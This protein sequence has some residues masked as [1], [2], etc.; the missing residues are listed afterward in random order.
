[1]TF[2]LDCWLV[3]SSLCG[4]VAGGPALNPQRKEQ[5]NPSFIPLFLHSFFRHLLHWLCKWKESEA[6]GSIPFEFVC[7]L[8]SSLCAPCAGWPPAHNRP[9][10]RAEDQTQTP[11]HSL[12]A[13]PFNLNSFSISLPILKEKRN[14]KNQIEWAAAV[15]LFIFIK[16]IHN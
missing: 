9:A 14:E 11:F 15:I 2:R 13:E 6:L 1:M 4:A 16:I 5:A 10:R 3:F 7:L 12:A 8:S